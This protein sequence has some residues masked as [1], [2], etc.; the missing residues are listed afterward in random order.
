MKE[1]IKILNNNLKL[2][3]CV[4]VGLDTELSKEFSEVYDMTLFIDSNSDWSEKVFPNNICTENLFY[5]ENKEVYEY[6]EYYSPEFDLLYIHDRNS[7]DFQRR[8]LNFFI[9][10]RTKVILAHPNT[11]RF[12]SKGYREISIRH[13][14]GEYRLYYLDIIHEALN[15]FFN[16]D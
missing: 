12:D 1:I 13:D 2:Y 14:G 3:T 7:L 16:Q 4:Q 5:S 10:K 15:N 9:K 6:L 11:F 8:V